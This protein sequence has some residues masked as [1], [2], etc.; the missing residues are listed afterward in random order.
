MH[1]IEVFFFN[2]KFAKYFLQGVTIVKPVVVGNIA[3]Y[4]GKKREEDGHTHEWTVYL[5]PYLNEDYS[6]FIKKVHFKLH[7]SYANPNRVITKPPYEVTETGWGEFEV[8]IKVHFV[9]PIERPV[10]M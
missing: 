9:D 5:K 7:D 10:I 2:F 3:K 1:L 6:I 8:V 4:F